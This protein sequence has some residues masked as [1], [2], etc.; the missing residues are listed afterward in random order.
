MIKCT[1][2]K[3]FA[4]LTNSLGPKMSLKASVINKVIMFPMAFVIKEIAIIT[5][6]IDSG[7]CKKKISKHFDS[8]I[9]EHGILNVLF[10]MVCNF[11]KNWL[12]WENANFKLVIENRIS[13]A[14]IIMIC[15]SCQKVLT[16]FGVVISWMYIGTCGK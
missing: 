2:L 1:T 10:L 8:R 16:I 13:P 5:A 6:F 9:R 7:A 11:L 14:V 3:V 4:S 15:G 12:T